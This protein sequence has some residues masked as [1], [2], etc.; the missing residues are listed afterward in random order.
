MV[1][2]C[3]DHKVGHHMTIKG[4]FQFSSSELRSCLANLLCTIEHFYQNPE[5]N[6]IFS[7]NIINHSHVP[8]EESKQAYMQAIEFPQHGH[9]T[10]SGVAIRTVEPSCKYLWE[11]LS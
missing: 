9:V 7:K 3:D 2:S 10:E 11:Y 6:T 1:V 4:F 8:M 5:I